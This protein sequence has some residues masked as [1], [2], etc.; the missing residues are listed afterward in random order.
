[1]YRFGGRFETEIKAETSTW[2]TCGK[3]MCALNGDPNWATC[4]VFVALR[5]SSSPGVRS[6]VM[7]LESGKHSAGD[8]AE[9]LVAS[10]LLSSLWLGSQA[11]ES[12][13]P[14]Y[15]LNHPHSDSPQ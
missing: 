6:V 3:G 7:A 14:P 11:Q 4:E 8:V 13:P 9:A 2:K 5:C 10:G 12:R 15:L 1:M